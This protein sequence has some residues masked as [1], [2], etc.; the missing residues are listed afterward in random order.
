[1]GEVKPVTRIQ[2]SLPVTAILVLC[3]AAF[4]IAAC[5]GGGAARK[6]DDSGHIIPTLAEQ[7]PAGTLY[8]ASI[9]KAARGECDEETLDVLPCLAYRGHGLSLI[10]L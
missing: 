6:R 8:A 1:M 4:S 5:K 9:G 7:D 10:H 2:S 3:V